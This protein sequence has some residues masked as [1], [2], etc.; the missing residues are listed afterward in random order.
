MVQEFEV[1]G[2]RCRGMRKRALLHELTITSCSLSMIPSAA[3]VCQD[4]IPPLPLPLN[5]HLLNEE[6]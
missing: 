1:Q 2:L 3:M 5:V 6:V 4:T